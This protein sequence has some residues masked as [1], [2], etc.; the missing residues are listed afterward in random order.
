MKSVAGHTLCM[1]PAWQFDQNYGS[2]LLWMYPVTRR[3][4]GAICLVT[5]LWSHAWKTSGFC[6]FLCF[7]LYRSFVPGSHSFNHSVRL[8]FS[9]WIRSPLH[10]NPG[11]TFFVYAALSSRAPLRVSFTPFI[12]T[13]F[14]LNLST[15]HAWLSPCRHRYRALR[16]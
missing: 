12:S 10:R 5:R 7:H 11:C 13:P 6:Q 9:C 16:C 2:S 15:L 4:E 8:L 1:S 14:M 3:D